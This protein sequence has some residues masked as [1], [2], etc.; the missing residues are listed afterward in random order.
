MPL[1]NGLPTAEERAERRRIAAEK[2][3][4]EFDAAHPGGFSPLPAAAAAAAAPKP[5][6]APPKPKTVSHSQ[7]KPVPATEPPQPTAT[8]AALPS[9]PK[10]AA[11]ATRERVPSLPKPPA[12]KPASP[13]PVASPSKEV[14]PIAPTAGGFEARM[15]AAAARGA[16]STLGKP[17]G[18]GGLYTSTG[19]YSATSR[20][21]RLRMGGAAP[22]GGGRRPCAQPLT[23]RHPT[24]RRSHASGRRAAAECSTAKVVR[25]RLRGGAREGAQPRHRR[26]CAAAPSRA[27]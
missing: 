7:T 14:A 13:K 4:A 19:M 6:A 11:A 1:P 3:A 24:P 8:V 22:A 5:S 18:A 9:D 26:P 15:A 20:I 27:P 12:A 16:V 17:D 2:A 10:P 25:G 21:D 23:R